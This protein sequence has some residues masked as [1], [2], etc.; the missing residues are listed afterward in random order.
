MTL[1]ATCIVDIGSFEGRATA[2]SHLSVRLVDIV[3]YPQ[4]DDFLILVLVIDV[5]RL[6]LDS[7]RKIFVIHIGGVRGIM[8]SHLDGN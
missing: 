2:I 4:F 5:A 8:L 1:P 3:D 7:N 6:D